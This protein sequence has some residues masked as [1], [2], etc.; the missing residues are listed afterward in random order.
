M[1]KLVA[2]LF[3]LDAHGSIDKALTF[4]SR[5]SGP[6]VRFQKK[7]KMIIPAYKQTDNQSLYRLVYARWLALSDVQKKEYHD[8]ATQSGQ[9]ISGWN[10]FLGKAIADPNT[11]LGLVSYWTF[12]KDNSNTAIDVSKNGN[13]LTLK[14]TW[15]SNAPTYAKSK[16]K[17]MDRALSFDGDDDYGEAS[18]IDLSL[19]GS[20]V[21]WFMANTVSSKYTL[22]G[23]YHGAN[24]NTLQ[25]D[26]GNLRG[27][28]DVGG[29]H[30]K[31]GD[32]SAGRWYNTIW[33]W[34]ATVATLD[35]NG[36]AQ[37]GVNEPDTEAQVRLV[38]GAATSP[39]AFNFDGLIDEVAIYNRPLPITER[40]Y[41][42]G[43]FR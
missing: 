10:Y 40:K 2:P 21:I 23:N 30:S 17:K 14:P 38:I 33:T 25:I 28:I 22:I 19:G 15:P 4:S 18:P 5:K 32:V 34:N 24:R 39:T 31:S 26:N 13:T 7:Q 20:F 3:S 36:V 27:S 29:V 43:V 12:N 6:Q 42:Y 16:N 11:Y 41:I 35:I 8:L 9:A 37:V 1:V